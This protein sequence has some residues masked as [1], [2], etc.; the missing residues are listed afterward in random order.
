MDPGL[1]RDD[2]L[3]R[4]TTSCLWQCL[5]MPSQPLLS[6]RAFGSSASLSRHSATMH[7]CR[8][9]LDPNPSYSLA[10]TAPAKPTCSK[11][12]PFSRP[13]KVCVAR[14]SPISRAPPRRW[15]LVRGRAC[16]HP[17]R[18]HRHRHWRPARLPGGPE[19]A[20]R[21]VR[22]DGETKSGSGI[23][24]DY[25]EMVWVT[26][27]MDGLF[28]GPASERRRFLDRL[29]LCFDPSYR[30]RAGR[31]DRAM[32]SRNRLLADGVTEHARLE[33]FEMVMAETGVAVAAARAEAVAALASVIAARRAAR[34]RV[35]P[36]LGARSPSKAAWNAISRTTPAVEVEDRYLSRS[37][38]D[39][40]NAIA[41][42]AARLMARTALISSSAT[43]PRRYPPG[44][45]P[46]ASRRRCC[47]A[48][49]SPTRKLVAERRDGLAPILLLDEIS[50][51]FRRTAPRCAV[52]RNP[53]S[54]S[55]GLDD[56]NRYCGIRSTRRNGPFPAP[57]R[58]DLDEPVRQPPAASAF[59]L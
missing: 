5:S 1:R 57:R 12:C 31:F 27:A 38:P 32:A 13:A 39:A 59:A 45:A 7:R 40:A 35:L 17:A 52:R 54:W 56:G 51:P 53:A 3:G 43:V 15:R 58:R 29:I 24:A 34:S 47:S 19:R 55:P 33:G 22:I 23:L 28:T 46:P 21:I 4:A 26:P 2:N 6:T 20:G 42:P 50:G 41:P 9:I 37:A 8:L 11:R 18:R 48:S 49:Y 16:A 36:F 25:V 14:L 44:S 10:L 30:T